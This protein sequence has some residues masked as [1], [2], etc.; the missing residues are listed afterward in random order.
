MIWK[1]AHH[2]LNATPIPTQVRLKRQNHP[3]EV[4]LDPLTT[5]F[6]NA[7]P[8]TPNYPNRKNSNWTEPEQTELENNEMVLLK[9]VHEEEL[10]CWQVVRNGDVGQAQLLQSSVSCP[11]SSEVHSWREK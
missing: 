7:A 5:H 11:C 9:H 4:Y 2:H 10:K 8:N 3:R 1:L 6:K